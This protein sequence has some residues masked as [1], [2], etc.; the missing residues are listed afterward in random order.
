MLAG[1]CIRKDFF[2]DEHDSGGGHVAVAGQN[3]AREGKCIVGEGE[4]FFD[5]VEDGAATG[6]DGPEVDGERVCAASDVM[7]EVLEG[8]ADFAGDLSG[9]MHVKAEF[10]DAPGDEVSGAGDAEGEEAIDGQ[11]CRLS[12]DERSGGTIGEDEEREYLFELVGLLEV[13]RA[14]FEI[15]DDDT[16]LGLGADDVV[17]GFEGVDGGVAAHE[18]DHGAFDGGIEAEVVDDFKVEAGRIEAGA[19]GDDHMGDGVAFCLRES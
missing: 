18:A 16:G 11:P 1:L 2:H 7:T 8:G 5:S 4:A 14:E 10:A 6:V 13:E 15:E 9:E 12:A 19:G 3:G 17:G